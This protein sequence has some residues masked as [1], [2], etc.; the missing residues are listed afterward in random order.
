[1]GAF[2]RVRGVSVFV[3]L[4]AGSSA[5][6]GQ[7][8]LSKFPLIKAI[9]DNAF[10]SVAAR[11]N[12]EQKFVE[13]HFAKVSE[14]FSDSGI[15]SDIWEIIA[16]NLEEEQ[17][18]RLEELNKKFGKLCK[19]VEWS[20]LFEEEFVFYGRFTSV[21]DRFV[22]FEGAM[23]GRMKSSGAE[24]NQKA[25]KALLAE[26]VKLI[27]Q[28]GG[29]GLVQSREW[30]AGD[31]SVLTIYPP[32]MDKFGFHL[33]AFKDLI[34]FAIG[35]EAVIRD[36]VGL[37]SGG[38]K[39]GV[40]STERFTTAFKALPPAEDVVVFWDV[41]RMMDGIDSILSAVSKGMGAPAG[42]KPQGEKPKKPDSEDDETGDEDAGMAD[43]QGAAVLGALSA[44]V[45]DVN[46]FDYVAEV[47]WTDGRRVFSE[48]ITRLKPSAKSSPLY[49]VIASS[50]AVSKFDRFIPK[51]TTDFSVSS[52]LSLVEAYRYVVNFV[53]KRIPDGKEAIEEMTKTLKREV[54]LDLEKDVFA[55]FDGQTASVTIGDEFAMLFKVTDE[56]KTMAQV[57]RLLDAIQGAMGQGQGLSLSKVKVKGDKEK[58]RSIS[59]PMMMMMGGLEPPVFGCSEGHLILASSADVVTEVLETADGTKPSIRESKRFKEEAIVPTE[60]AVDSISYTD[61]S[62]L[63]E[64]LQQAFG[65]MAMGVGMMGMMGGQNMPPEVASVISKAGPILTKLGTVL[66]KLDFFQSSSSCTTFDG[67]QWKTRSVQNYKP[68]KKSSAGSDDE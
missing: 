56:K 43:P 11:S 5:A 36:P 16:D 24:S 6:L 7:T 65:G 67:T 58:F 52:G 1:M 31:A 38:D 50:K 26:I 68:A 22:T 41:A 47:G 64:Q 3:V 40:S 4:A 9:P 51:D 48:S 46:I 21:V 44:L 37:L 28:E 60:G 61:D 42:E 53:E 33:A 45:K 12:P 34:F 59:H 17:L 14:A 10:I 25:L 39:K 13:E 20:R 27:Q 23:V 29:E 15:M 32:N 35:T 2:M 19:D 18:D 57:D 63:G 66:S 30:K 49:K 55:L 62:R 54:N 8:D